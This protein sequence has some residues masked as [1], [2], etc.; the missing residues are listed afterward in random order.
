LFQCFHEFLTVKDDTKNLDNFRT[1]LSK[2][3]SYQDLYNDFD[4]HN[5]LALIE[6]MILIF[7]TIFQRKIFGYIP[8]DMSYTLLDFIHANKGLV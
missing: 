7:A 4:V 2:I 1:F 8:S 5:M 6:Q 3:G